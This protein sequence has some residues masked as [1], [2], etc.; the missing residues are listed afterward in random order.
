MV[1]KFTFLRFTGSI[2][3]TAPHWIRPCY[4]MMSFFLHRTEQT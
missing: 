4:K 3:L 1:N 2:A